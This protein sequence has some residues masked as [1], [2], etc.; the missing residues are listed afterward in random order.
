MNMDVI[1]EGI[2][3]DFHA[4]HLKELGCEYGQGYLY[5]PPLEAAAAG[6]FLIQKPS[7]DRSQALAHGAR[8]GEIA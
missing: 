4:K 5:A 3:K 2:E 8:A 6:D 1:A 7:F